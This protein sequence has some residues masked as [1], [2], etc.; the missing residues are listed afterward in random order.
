[1]RLLREVNGWV[2]QRVDFVEDNVDGVP[3]EIWQN[4]AES[5][6]RGRGDCEDYALAKLALLAALGFDR[7]DLFLVIAR[8]LVARSHH[9]VLAVRTGGRFVVLDN[10]TDELIEGDRANDYRPIF[11][12]SA[13]GRWIHGYSGSPPR[14][15]IQIAAAASAIS[16]P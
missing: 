1:M 11:S 16:A 4:A 2:N 15:P 7:E 8:D 5:L 3:A 13:A 6:R 10:A 12:Y 14:P 9:A